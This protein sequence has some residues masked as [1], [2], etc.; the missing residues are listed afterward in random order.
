MARYSR[1]CANHTLTDKSKD[2]SNLSWLIQTSGDTSVKHKTS[3]QH[4][5]TCWML[6]QDPL[7]LSQSN[8]KRFGQRYALAVLWYA[9]QGD[10]Y[11]KEK[12][13]WMSEK[14]ECTWYGVVCNSWGTII[15]LDLGFNDLNGILPREL[16]LLQ[17]LQEID[18]HGNDLIGVLPPGILHAWTNMQTLRLHMNGFMGSIPSEIGY[19]TSLRE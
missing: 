12:Q 10:K 2:V 1:L 8:R 17:T 15:E 11:W 5:G 18:V 16:A 9:T 7:R 4:K 3:P 14:H 19:M 13:N 6:R